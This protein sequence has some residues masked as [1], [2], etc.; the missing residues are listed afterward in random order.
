MTGTTDIRRVMDRV[1]RHPMMRDVPFEAA[2]D[3]TVD[4]IQLMG[5]PALYE[6]R[7]A[8][9]E[10]RGWRGELPCDFHKMVQARLLDGCG[11][12]VPGA[13]FRAS[14]D[15]FHMSPE[16]GPLPKGLTYKLQGRVMF[17][18]VEHADVEVA[19]RAFAVDADGLP[20]IPDNA[21]FLRGLESY[22]KLQWFTVLFDMGRI[23]LAV[24]QNAQQEYAWAAG[25]AQSEGSRLSLDEAE[26]LFNSFKSLLPRTHAHRGGFATDGA[27]EAWR[28]HG[29]VR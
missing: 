25:D 23:P 17:A 24:L 12:P 16:K 28:R 4:F 14:G 11:R 2:V 3:W 29:N 26:T 18:S 7:T 13:T 10:V 19:Y 8:V 20:L 1:T 6:D 22:V 27:R 21:S 5:T 9:V 15:T